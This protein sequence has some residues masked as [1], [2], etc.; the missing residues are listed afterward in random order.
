[1][2]YYMI[3]EVHVHDRAWVPDYLADV[4]PIVRA[5]GGEFLARSPKVERLEGE[6]AP[7]GVVTAIAFPSRQAA[8]DFYTSEA[9]RPYREARQAGASTR[10]VLV[11]GMDIASE[12]RAAD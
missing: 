10:M 9:Y 5:Y 8:L 7:A 12:Q 11:A 2:K 1:M 6:G 3:A 4:D